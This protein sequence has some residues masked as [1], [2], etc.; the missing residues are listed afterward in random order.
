MDPATEAP[1][2]FKQSSRKGKRA[3]R[4]NVDVTDIQEGLET[5]RDEVIRGGVIAE[6]PS[7]ELFT[8]DTA[9]DKSIKEAYNKTHKPLKADEILAQRSA[10]PAIDS[11]KR[12]NSRTTDGV[13]EPTGKR[14]RGGGIS[15]K[16]LDRLRR[17]AYGGEGV[18]KDV[19]KAPGAPD[20]DPWAEAE[21]DAVQETDPL[22]SFLEPPKPIREPR[23]L[24]HA[25]IS[26]AATGKE[27]P[28]VKK[29]EPQISYNPQ[30][31]LYFEAFTKA[32]EEEV[33]A[34]R[35]RL[36]ETEEEWQ[37]QE[38]IARVQQ[39]EERDE[40]DEDEESAWEGLDSD[41]EGSEWLARRRPE[42]KTQA[43]R[44]KIKRKK[45][46]ER[47]AAAEAHEKLRKRQAAEIKRIAKAVEAKAKERAMTVAEE[48]AACDDEPGD[49]RA[50]RRRRLGRAPVPEPPFEMVLPSELQESLRLL[51][52][53]GNL[54]KDRFRSMLVRGKMESRRAITQPKQAKRF[55]TEKWSYKD[56]KLK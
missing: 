29:P 52:P 33:E 32:G 11:R 1:R 9:G 37:K 44:N 14:R 4:K 20:H 45:E 7:G 31:T 18:H 47:R 21:E 5:V 23:T 3:W 8:V 40:A 25:A 13:L 53:E 56:W 30:S 43:Q 34:E 12:S 22:F 55:T 36:C 16:E 10:V 2:Q 49:D 28:A 26:L 38:M 48:G 35:K 19:I 41:I 51:K 50:L 54:L 42:R 27:I 24:K 17:I 39:E 6:K 46:A 15:H